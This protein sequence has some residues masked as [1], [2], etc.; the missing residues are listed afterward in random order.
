[1][2]AKK[3]TSIGPYLKAVVGA[4]TAALAVAATAA[5]DNAISLQEGIYIASA[6]FVG[7]G[8]VWVTPNTP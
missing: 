3:K 6:F 4:V 5:T 2:A 8:A 7:L 1:M